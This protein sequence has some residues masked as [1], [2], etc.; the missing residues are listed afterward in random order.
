MFSWNSNLYPAAALAE[1]LEAII[2]AKKHGCP[3][4]D[5]ACTAACEVGNLP[6]L[7]WLRAR[8]CPWNEDVYVAAIDMLFEDYHSSFVNEFGAN[9]TNWFVNATP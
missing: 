8:G 9:F 1:N 5:K 2:W 3:W 6:I 7:E 4:D